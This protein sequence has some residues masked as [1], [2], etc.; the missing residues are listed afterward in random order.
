[1]SSSRRRAWIF[2]LLL[3]PVLSLGSTGISLYGQAKV[4]GRSADGIW[5]FVAERPNGAQPRADIVGT[6]AMATFSKTA[7]DTVAQQT[8]RTA[9]VAD[10]TFVVDL[11]MPDGTLQTF[12]ARESAILAPELAAAFAAV[13]G[14]R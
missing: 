11:P 10:A 9:R 3:V 13:I 4:Q 14:T 2:G 12:L 1:M 8:S 5:Q 7:F 6:P